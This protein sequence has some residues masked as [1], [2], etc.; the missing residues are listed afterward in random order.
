MVD[1]PLNTPVSFLPLLLATWPAGGLSECHS[2]ESLESLATDWH[3]Q[4]K[5]SL[6]TQWGQQVRALQRVTFLFMTSHS[7]CLPHSYLQP[8]QRSQTFFIS[9]GSEIRQQPALV[10]GGVPKPLNDKVVWVWQHSLSLVIDSYGCTNRAGWLASLS[11]M[12]MGLGQGLDDKIKIKIKIKLEI[13][14]KKK[15]KKKKQNK[16]KKKKKK[17]NTTPSKRAC[18]RCH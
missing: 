17:K 3:M 16:K 8:T 12:L 15:K 18:T 6:L 2:S 14:K 13:E 9:F 5:P 4:N 7:C 10:E 1:D 11:K